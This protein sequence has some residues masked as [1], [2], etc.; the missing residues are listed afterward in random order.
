MKHGTADIREIVIDDPQEFHRR[1]GVIVPSPRLKPLGLS[2]F[3][4]S[5]AFN[6]SEVAEL[7]EFCGEDPAYHIVS[8]PPSGWYVN[9]YIPGCNVYFLAR[10]D[11]YPGMKSHLYLHKGLELFLEEGTQAALSII[12]KIDGSDDT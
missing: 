6:G 10:G 9:R 2:P 8:M 5:G 11:A 12:T 4:F 3:S 7:L 1:V